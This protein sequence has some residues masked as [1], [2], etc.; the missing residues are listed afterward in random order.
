[1]KRHIFRGGSWQKQLFPGITT[2]ITVCMVGLSQREPQTLCLLDELPAF[3]ILSL[4]LDLF[5]LSCAAMLSCV[6]L[7]CILL[8]CVFCLAFLE[9][10]DEYC[11]D[12]KTYLLSRSGC[13]DYVLR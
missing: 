7:C 5:V 2:G 10:L 4:V 8:S 13:L 1:M 11:E 12:G 9:F 3:W 6:A